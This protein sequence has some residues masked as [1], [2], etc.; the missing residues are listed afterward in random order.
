[1]DRNDLSSLGWGILPDQKF[2]ADTKG[3]SS[4]TLAFWS[5]NHYASL[6]EAHLLNF[7]W[8]CQVDV[9]DDA[10]EI[11]EGLERNHHRRRLGG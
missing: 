8:Y 4:P 7:S 5:F 3:S 9:L 10:K 6:L 11:Y 1:M 2:R